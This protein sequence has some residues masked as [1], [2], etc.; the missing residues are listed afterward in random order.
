MITYVSKLI[1]VPSRLSIYKASRNY[2][3]TSYI[4]YLTNVFMHKILSFR[5]KE[6]AIDYFHSLKHEH[7]KHIKQLVSGV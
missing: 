1:E 3:T 2:D 7:Q 6:D 4:S 5:V